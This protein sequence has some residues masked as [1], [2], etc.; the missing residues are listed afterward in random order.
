MHFQ[1][2]K[3]LNYSQNLP[4]VRDG[5][6]VVCVEGDVDGDGRLEEPAALVGPDEDTRSQGTDA[7][8]DLLVLRRRGHIF[9]LRQ[10][11]LIGQRNIQILH[12]NRTKLTVSIAFTY[13]GVVAAFLFLNTENLRNEFFVR[14]DFLLG[15]KR[16]LLIRPI[17]DGCER[18][19]G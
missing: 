5:Q 12:M 11:G 14:F 15:V 3:I 7:V 1:F 16:P 10:P 6:V 8:G 19:L 9:A 17:L 18:N 4:L 13:F 2:Y